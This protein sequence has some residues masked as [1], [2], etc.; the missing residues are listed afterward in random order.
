MSIAIAVEFFFGKA[1]LCR[2]KRR[3]VLLL[4]ISLLAAAWVYHSERQHY[5]AHPL[6]WSITTFLLGPEMLVAYLIQRGR[7]LSITCGECHAQVPA[8]RDACAKCGAEFPA[9]ERT[10]CEIFAA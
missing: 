3:Q 4:F 5:G 6:A 8:K 9:P 10:G 2:K 7:P 1:G